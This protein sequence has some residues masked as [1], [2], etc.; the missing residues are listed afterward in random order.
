[1]T[2]LEDAHSKANAYY[3]TAA[4]LMNEL[5]VFDANRYERAGAMKKNGVSELEKGLSAYGNSKKETGTETAKAVMSVKKA[6]VTSIPKT[7]QELQGVDKSIS[8]KENMMNKEDGLVFKIQIGVFKNKPN[9]DALNAIPPISEVYLADR[10]LTKYF[11]GRYKT[12]GEANSNV[13]KV[14]EAGFSGAFVV[15]FKDG[16]QITLTEELK[17]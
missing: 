16:V 12:F 15:V 4:G 6:E 3:R 2:Y 11:S 17:K 9:A 13:A 14:Q 5:A 7:Y 8:P 1:M 10:G